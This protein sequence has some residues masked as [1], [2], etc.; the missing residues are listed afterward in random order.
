VSDLMASTAAI[1]GSLPA[2]RIY[3][4]DA[5]PG[6]RMSLDQAE[7]AQVA[8][9]K[10][11]LGALNNIGEQK[12]VDSLIVTDL[13]DL[14]RNGAI[15]D[16]V[17]ISGD[18]DL[19]IAV[20]VAQSFGVRVHVLA[21][22]DPSRNVSHSL[23]IEADSVHMLDSAWFAKH[24]ENKVPSAPERSIPT[25]TLAKQDVAPPI[26]KAKSTKEIDEIALEVSKELLAS[27]DQ[28]QLQRL[29]SH[30]ADQE[31]VPPEYDR[32]L[33]AKVAAAR[34]GERLSGTQMRQIRGVFVRTVRLL[35]D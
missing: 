29:R 22:G 6:P 1:S 9:V 2:L 19:R 33:I 3:W 8:G 10:L 26:A 5:M 15:A 14:A 18:E 35:S 20:Q 12:G 25:N 21:A 23:Q 16:A 31:T 30:F 17:L 32:K 11:R 4:Y 24:F 28:D 27:E 34:G 13:I 7:L